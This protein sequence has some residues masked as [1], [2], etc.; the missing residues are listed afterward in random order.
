MTVSLPACRVEP[1]RDRPVWFTNREERTRRGGTATGAFAGPELADATLAWILR[2]YRAHGDRAERDEISYQIGRVL[3]VGGCGDAAF[4]EMVAL[5]RARP[6]READLLDALAACEEGLAHRPVETTA[7][8]WA[9][10]AM[11]QNL[12]RLRLIRTQRRKGAPRSG[13]T[14]GPGRSGAGACA[15]RPRAARREG[16]S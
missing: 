10:L 4:W 8:T 6:G 2:T 3:R 16:G 15:S 13:T 14:P 11:T 12:L 5:E 1:T 9:S 7:S